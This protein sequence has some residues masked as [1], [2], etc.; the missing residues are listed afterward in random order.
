MLKQAPSIGFD[1]AEKLFAD[2][3]AAVPPEENPDI[4]RR[5]Q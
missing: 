5:Y 3:G 1:F 4:F 2:G